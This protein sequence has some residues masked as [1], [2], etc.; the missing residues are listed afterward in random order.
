M[1]TFAGVETAW[2]RGRQL[3]SIEAG[4]RQALRD[5]ELDAS[6]EELATT[7][8]QPNNKRL[9]N[10][11]RGGSKRQRG[12]AKACKTAGARA[13]ARQQQSPFGTTATIVLV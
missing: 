12:E 6:N 4:H 7:L 5:S 9:S 2:Q 3:A 1:L 10:R 8:L 13:G 11:P